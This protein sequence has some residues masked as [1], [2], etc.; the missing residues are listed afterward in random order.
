MLVY[1]P[2]PSRPVREMKMKPSLAVV[3]IAC[4]DHHAAIMLPPLSSNLLTAPDIRSLPRGHRHQVPEHRDR[5][6]DLLDLPETSDGRPDGQQGSDR[7]RPPPP[8]LCRHHQQLQLS[9]LGH[10]PPG[11]H[12]CWV[13]WKSVISPQTAILTTNSLWRSTFISRYFTLS[14]SAKTQLRFPRVDLQW[15][16]KYYNWVPNIIVSAHQPSCDIGS[17]LLVEMWRGRSYL[18]NVAGRPA[19]LVTQSLI[20]FYLVFITKHKSGLLKPAN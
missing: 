2:T 15:D 19:Y 20:I 16:R 14:I 8:P 9:S 13:S 11:G 5:R 10:L 18:S 12:Q 4:H 3:I 7:D 1:D 17:G 6:V